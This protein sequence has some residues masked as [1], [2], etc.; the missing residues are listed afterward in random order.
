MQ[1]SPDILI[2]GAGPAGCAA[3]YDLARAGKRVL[4]LDKRTFPRHKACAAGLT[5]KTLAALR[6]SVEPVIER[7]CQEIVLQQH[8]ADP[9]HREVRI[10]LAQK[11][12]K[13]SG[14]LICATTVREAFD[15]FCLQQT[16]ASGRNGGSVT[17]L[18][19]AALLNLRELSTHIE[20]DIA[21]QEGQQTLRAPVL[22][23]ADGSNGQTRALH[24][25]TRNAGTRPD[26]TAEPDNNPEW[27]TRGFALEAT[28][29]YTALP[30]QLPQGGVPHDLVFDFAPIPGGYGWL[31][32]KGDHINVGIGIFTPDSSEAKLKEINRQLLAGYIHHKLGV[33]LT[34]IDPAVVHLTGQHLGVG[35]DCYIPQGRVLLLGDAAGL[36][37]PLTGEGIHSAIISGQAAAAAILSNEPEIAAAYA[38][39]LAPLQQTLAFSR[40]AALA[41]Y[42]QPERGFRLMRMPFMR[43]L[44]LKTYANGVNPT[45]LR[46][47][48]AAIAML[49]A[50]KQTAQKLSRKRYTSRKQT[51]QEETSLGEANIARPHAPSPPSGASAPKN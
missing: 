25:R 16:L 48:L 27:F 23:G 1:L 13:A 10:R 38:R 44:I 19:I 37:D 3:A 4:L 30:S 49:R 45:H 11:A 32:P 50:V 47:G 35:G 22:L 9:S 43:S 28:I 6:Y 31:F 24:A 36:V 12:R 39:R 40:R 7:Y 8:S 41:F 42:A 2:V 29:P 5:P 21:T 15:A 17:L 26:N 33:D 20:L 18:K 46:Q 34:T 51:R 14:H